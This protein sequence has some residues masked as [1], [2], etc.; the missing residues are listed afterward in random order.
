M[1][2]YYEHGGI[3]I[4]HGDCRDVIEEWEGLRTYAFDLLLTDPPYGL[5]ASWS[6]NPTGGFI[7]RAVAE[8]LRRWDHMPSAETMKRLLGICRWAVVWG[9]NYLG[10]VLGATTAPLVWDKTIRGM[11]FADGEFAWTNFNHGS[12]RIF[13]FD[14]RTPE[15]RQYGGVGGRIHPTQKPE[16]LMIWSIIQAKQASSILDPFMGGGTSLA[17]AKR[18]GR[19]A[20]G[21]ECDER[22]CE[23]A[24]K[25]LAQNVLP[26]EFDPIVPIQQDLTN[27]VR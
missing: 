10:N 15:L 27:E 22:Y 19:N 3:T 13:S 12:L 21:I 6:E 16:D 18:L 24:A 1:K 4:Y 9:G 26:L 25:R 23:L 8:D 17:A 20:I 7:S 2:P 11:H 5:S 14:G